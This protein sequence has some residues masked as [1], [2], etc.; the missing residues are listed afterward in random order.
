MRFKTFFKIMIS[1]SIT[2]L[3]ISGW[4]P[5]E[6]LRRAM[7]SPVNLTKVKFIKMETNA[8]Y[9]MARLTESFIQKREGTVRA[10]MQA[11]KMHCLVMMNVDL[12]TKE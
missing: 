8:S 1:T 5:G 4:P 3:L 12:K 10:L 2:C 9:F 11:A 7:P 6:P